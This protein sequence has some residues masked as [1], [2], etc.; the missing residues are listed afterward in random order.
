MAWWG[1]EGK[2]EGGIYSNAK[3]RDIRAMA[4]FRFPRWV[5]WVR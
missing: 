1:G 4:V 2:A 5:L 3:T